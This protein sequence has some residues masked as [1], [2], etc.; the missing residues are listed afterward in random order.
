MTVAAPVVAAVGLCLVYGVLGARHRGLQATYW[1]RL[2]R[3]WLPRLDRIARRVGL[4]YAAYEL[5]PRELAGSVEEPVEAVEATLADHGFERMPLAA[6]KVLGDGRGEA[7]SWALREGPLAE[8]QLHVMLFSAGEGTTELYA[9]EEY[10][11]FHPRYATRHYRGIDYDPAAG[12]ERLQRLLG[13]SLTPA[14]TP[15]ES[16]PD[17]GRKAHERAP[18]TGTPT[19]TRLAPGEAETPEYAD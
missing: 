11:A 2:R 10:N 15:P 16:M 13:A 19:A 18:G 7:G 6:W 3:R 8:R 1:N 12:R 9:H 4:G 14:A 5:H 17:D